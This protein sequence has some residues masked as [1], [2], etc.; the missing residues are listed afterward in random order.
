[1]TMTGTTN[2]WCLPSGDAGNRRADG[3]CTPGCNTPRKTGPH[4]SSDEPMNCRRNIR[5][6]CWAVSVISRLAM[7]RPGAANAALSKKG[8]LIG[9]VG[10]RS[11]RRLVSGR[12]DR[13]QGRHRPWTSSISRPEH[14][15]SL[16]LRGPGRVADVP[17]PSPAGVSRAPCR[18]PCRMPA[19]RLPIGNRLLGRH[20]C[21]AMGGVRSGSGSGFGRWL[22]SGAASESV[23]GSVEAVGA[24]A[25]GLALRAVRAG[26]Y[27]LAVISGPP[28]A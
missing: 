13:Q 7:H 20:F 22:N 8:L 6:P 3:R 5:F 25:G 1:M 12:Q 19:V 27:R 10:A 15:A 2:R 17:L 16:P 28:G 21:R 18:K 4:M 11:I 14:R 23:K 9:N 26:K 24:V